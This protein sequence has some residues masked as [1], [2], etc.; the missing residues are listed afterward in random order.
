[1]PHI[2]SAEYLKKN[3]DDITPNNCSCLAEQTNSQM[4]MPVDF[5]G[6]FCSR[7]NFKAFSH[8]YVGAR[9]W[10]WCGEGFFFLL[11]YLWHTDDDNDKNNN[12]NF[13]PQRQWKNTQH[14][15]FSFSPIFT[16]FCSHNFARSFSYLSI[17]CNLIRIFSIPKERKCA[18]FLLHW[19]LLLGN[20]T[21]CFILCTFW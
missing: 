13:E 20:A 19:T 10:W 2:D 1:M 5:F 6:R 18:L 4:Q 15:T 9:R 12:N 17:V 14:P 7:Y 21:F 11:L 3:G 16:I 8:F